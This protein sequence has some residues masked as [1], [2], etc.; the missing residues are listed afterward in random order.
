MTKLYLYKYK[1]P[2]QPRLLRKTN[3]FSRI[4]TVVKKFEF[5]G[6]VQLDFRKNK[7]KFSV[8]FQ[9]TVS[10]STGLIQSCRIKNM[11]ISLQRKGRSLE[12]SII[13][14]KK[15]ESKKRNIF[16]IC[17]LYY[18][19]C[20]SLLCLISLKTIAKSLLKNH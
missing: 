8:N 14:F 20:F 17:I 1:N 16:F 10:C 5:K 6:T 18:F 12:E 3:I 15:T 4:I 11:I 2:A 7:T 19:I 13:L 9:L